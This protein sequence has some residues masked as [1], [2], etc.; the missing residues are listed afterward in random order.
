MTQDVLTLIH[1]WT[2][3][4]QFCLSELFKLTEL[5]HLISASDLQ[6]WNPSDINVGMR[7]WSLLPYCFTFAVSKGMRA[8]KLCNNKILQFLTGGAG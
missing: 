8:V 2:F 4:S 7:L 1:I 5:Y 6:M 3:Y